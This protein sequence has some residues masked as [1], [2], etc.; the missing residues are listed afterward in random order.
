MSTSSYN[1]HP[2]HTIGAAKLLLWDS[3]SL[4]GLGAWR[5]LGRVADAAVLVSGAAAEKAIAVRGVSQPIARRPRSRRFSLSL[6][7]LESAGPELHDLLFSDGGAPSASAAGIAVQA[8]S[9]RLYGAEQHELAHPYGLLAELPAGV[10]NLQSSVGGSGGVIPATNYHYW[11]VPFLA[12]GGSARFLCSAAHVGPVTV[13]SGQQVT[14]TFTA[15]ADYVP[16]GYRVYVHSSNNI[17]SSV[18]ALE[19][20]G[21]SP[22]VISSHA[23]SPA[24]SAPPEPLFELR[25]PNGAALYE[26]GADYTLNVELGQVARSPG[27]AVESGQAAVAIYAQRSSPAVSTGMGQALAPE[28]YRRIKLLQLMPEDPAQQGLGAGDLDPA[29]W[30]ESGVEFELY[31][32]AITPGDTQWPF[33]DGDFG[34]GASLLW[35]CMYDGAAGAVGTVRSSFSVLAQWG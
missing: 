35:E 26:A 15:P 34:E 4:G 16:D 5:S 3:A 31:R 19:T 8:E 20:S 6:R 23:G 13:G 28:R 17:G 14:L 11:V 2:F 9:L 22:I 7:L 10:S 24:Y 21:G 25:S 27:G 12:Y 18:L 29:S 32:V 30:R 1:Y 33:A